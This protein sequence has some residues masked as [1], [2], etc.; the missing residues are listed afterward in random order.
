M[1]LCPGDI[2]HGLLFCF[3]ISNKSKK[4]DMSGWLIYQFSFDIFQAFS[5]CFG[6]P[7][8]DD[9]E[10]DYADKAIKP[11]CS[12]SAKGFVEIWECQG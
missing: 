4:I 9:N 3:S 1:E 11:K 12:V 8:Q 5:F 10:P 7:G 2:S 6:Q